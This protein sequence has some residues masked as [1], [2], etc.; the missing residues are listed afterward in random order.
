MAEAHAA[1]LIHRDLKP[2]NIF[3]ASR[4]GRFDFAKLLDFGLVK[5]LSE[6]AGDA[7]LSR[8]G[9][10]RGTPQFMAPEQAVGSRGLDHR[11][12]LYALGGVAYYLLTGRPPFEGDTSVGVMIAHVRDPVVPPSKHRP[13]TPADLE[14]VVLACLEKDPDRRPPDAAA[15]GR[16][17][18]ACASAADWDAD[19][20]ADW[21]RR[22]ATAP[23]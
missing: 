14:S 6:G 15:L 2:A 8:E 19:R 22:R 9:S 1:G 18:A 3:A 4:G 5:A 20:A 12:D 17:L 16:A 13:D 10:V 11:C 23:A 21:W 7:Q